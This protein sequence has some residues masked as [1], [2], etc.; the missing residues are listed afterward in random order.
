MGGKN[1]WQ[2][3]NTALATAGD[4][5]YRP[6]RGYKKDH[7]SMSKHEWAKIKPG[8]LADAVNRMFSVDYNGTWTSFASTKWYAE[9]ELNIRTGY[10]S[11]E[12]IHNNIHNI[13]GGSSLGYDPNDKHSLDPQG[14]YGLGHMSDVPVA[15]FDPIFWMHHWYILSPSR[16]HAD[17]NEC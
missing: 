10:M 9:E 16:K 6:R 11:L 13:T 15:A 7:K 5:F 2:S 14:I 17:T 8:N 3:C 4:R 12:F 1:E